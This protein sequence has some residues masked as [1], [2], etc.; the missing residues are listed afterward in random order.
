MECK[1]DADPAWDGVVYAGLREVGR[2]AIV[3]FKGT[4]TVDDHERAHRAL[5]AAL[6][7]DPQPGATAWSAGL[8]RRLSWDAPVE[9]ARDV[10]ALA[11]RPA[12]VNAKPAR[13]GGVLEALRCI[14]ASEEKGIDTYVGGMFE[15]GVGRAQLHVLAA[16]FSPDGPNDV[17]PLGVGEVAPPRPPRLAVDDD[18]PGFGGP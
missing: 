9:A 11:V 17:A 13:M 16:L 3:D 10:A 7:E 6:I 18:S 1:I 8:C 15:V 2:V 14:A 4:G 12:A 5:P